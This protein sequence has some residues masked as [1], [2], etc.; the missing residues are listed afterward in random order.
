MG[1]RRNERLQTE[2]K[3]VFKPL[4]IVAYSNCCHWGCTGSYYE[5]DDDFEVRPAAGCALIQQWARVVGV[6]IES[7]V[8]PHEENTAIQIYFLEPLQLDITPSDPEEDKDG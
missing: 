3:V 1:E 5:T 2:S 6:G 7:I 8:K 4:G